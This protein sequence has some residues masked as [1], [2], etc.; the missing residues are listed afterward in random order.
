MSTTHSSSDVPQIPADKTGV[1]LTDAEIPPPPP[2]PRAHKKI[3]GNLQIQGLRIAA[4]VVI[5]SAWEIC[6]RMGYID[7]FMV[8]S[9]TAVARFLGE[10][11]TSGDLWPHI[12]ATVT[13]TLLA[14]AIGSLAGVITGLILSVSPRLNAV[15][16]PFLT[17][18]N[19]MPRVALAPL[20]LLWFGLGQTSKVMMGISTV[21]FILVLNTYAGVKSIDPDLRTIG[22]V[23]GANR[24]QTFTKLIVPATIP[25][26]F[27]GLRLAVVYAL[28]GVVLAEMLASQQGLGQLLQYYAGLFQVRGV[29]GVLIVLSLLAVAGSAV[30]AAVERRIL[31]WQRT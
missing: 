2:T 27:A 12:S 16:D 6:S 24:T 5:C 9:P 1:L 23:M 21:Y 8:S 4:L 29:F 7:P 14:F 22:V 13:A 30:V 25:S 31:R 17:I 15:L 19:A 11:F 28:L 3:A 18:A 20:F 10:A 26:V